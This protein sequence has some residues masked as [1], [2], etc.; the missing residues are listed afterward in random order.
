MVK[1]GLEAEKS[2][3]IATYSKYTPTILQVYSNLKALKPRR[4]EAREM[5]LEV[6]TAR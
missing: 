5:G 6:T 1:V 4:E 3:K 2:G